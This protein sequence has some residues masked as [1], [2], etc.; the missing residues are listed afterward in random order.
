MTIIVSLFFLVACVGLSAAETVLAPDAVKRGRELFAA[1]AVCHTTEMDR[2]NPGPDLRGVIG[3]RA[4]AFPGFRFSRAMRTSQR[5]WSA[6]S[7]DEFLA[8]PQAA[9][10]GNTMPSPGM[11]DER[12]RSDLIE[13]LKTLK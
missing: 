9:V 3:R 11:P 7:L 12:R 13:Y 8:D 2:P 1:C 4:G 10:P 5:V 6:E